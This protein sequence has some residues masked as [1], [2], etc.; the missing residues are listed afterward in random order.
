MKTLKT[1]KYSREKKSLPF[2]FINSM[3]YPEIKQPP[4]KSSKQLANPPEVSLGTSKLDNTS[5][6]SLILCVTTGED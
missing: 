4:N 1:F 2:L 3:V 5:D 6:E